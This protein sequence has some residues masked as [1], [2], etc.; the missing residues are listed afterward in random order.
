[1]AERLGTGLQNLLHLFES[2]SDL[3][4]KAACDQAAF[5]YE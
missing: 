1:M 4:R 3:L 2:G 5:F